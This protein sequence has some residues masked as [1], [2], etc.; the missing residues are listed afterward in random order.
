ML[1]A[2]QAKCHAKLM[3]RG[4]RERMPSSQAPDSQK[5]ILLATPGSDLA[6]LHSTANVEDGHQRAK[7]RRPHL[8]GL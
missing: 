1:N 8:E 3:L 2:L 4:G 7:K 6:Y 5:P